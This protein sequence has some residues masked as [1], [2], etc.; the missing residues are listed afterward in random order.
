MGDAQEAFA[1]YLALQWSA[2]RERGFVRSKSTFWLRR[3]PQ[4]GVLNV[5]RSRY[6]TRE[7]VSFTIN[8]SVASELVRPHLPRWAA[9][10]EGSRPSEITCQVRR[11]IGSLLPDDGDR[12]WDVDAGTDVDALAASLT[13]LLD[14]YALPF[15][16]PLLE[17]RAFAEYV[18]E[19]CAS[20][21]WAGISHWR[22]F[23]VPLLEEVGASQAQ[24]AEARALVDAN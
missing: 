7:A 5:Q 20:P 13:E 15:L 9:W 16:E 3:R 10:R 8:V 11:R 17:P 21:D 19:R 18:F 23:L 14:G 22:S 12:W 1:G 2:L 24:R 4:W 6:S